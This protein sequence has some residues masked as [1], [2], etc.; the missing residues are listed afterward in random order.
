M[1]IPR[2]G[3]GGDGAV[4]L[5]RPMLSIQSLLARPGLLSADRAV[6][7]MAAG[8]FPGRFDRCAEWMA[9]AQELGVPRLQLEEVL[10][11]SALFCGFPRAITSFELLCRQWPADP[12]EA[13]TV[14]A[15]ER[16]ARGNALFDKVYAEKAGSVRTLLRHAHGEL[17]DYIMENA[18]GRILTRE[19]LCM[20][21]REL[22]AVAMLASSDQ[23]PQMV[24]HGRGA[25]RHGATQVEVAETIVTAIG[26]PKAAADLARKVRLPAG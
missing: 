7:G 14:P 22:S 8:I 15:T 1:P 21:I 5:R 25:L 4:G 6:I 2:M 26:E 23:I 13:N 17:A 9:N 24:A 18:Y 19:G 3:I 20:R 12:P 16:A 11:Q 10:L